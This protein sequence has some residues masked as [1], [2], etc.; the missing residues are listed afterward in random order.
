MGTEKDRKWGERETI[1]DHV[2][3][4]TGT[5][6]QTERD[7]HR[8]SETEREKGPFIQLLPCLHLAGGR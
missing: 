2:R 8:E 3:R 6:R 1:R 7:T 4:E 5:E